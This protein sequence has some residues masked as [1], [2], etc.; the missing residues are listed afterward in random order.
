[1]Q[2]RYCLWLILLLCAWYNTSAQSAIYIPAE[3]RVYAHPQDTIAIYG[4]IINNGRIVNPAGS[5]INFYGIRWANDTQGRITDESSD[6]ISGTGGFVRFIQPNPLTG[7]STRQWVAGGYNTTSQTGASF[8]GIRVESEQG[9]WLEDLNDL[10][11]NRTL[12]L[13]K[14]HLFLNGWNL[15]IGRFSPGEILHYSPE[16]FIVTDSAFGGGRLY[17]HR[18]SATDMHVVFP[19]GTR[20]GSYTPLVVRTAD[21]PAQF[22]ASVWEDVRSQVTSGDSLWDESV[23]RTWEL[24]TD[25]PGARIFMALAHQV[26]DE[27]AVFSA[28]R[29]SAYIARFANGNWET[30][31]DQH[32]P[33]SPNIFTTGT[34]DPQGAINTKTVDQLPTSAYFTKFVAQRTNNP[35]KT[36]LNFFG[37]Y[38][39]ATD[40]VLL[41]WI[42]GREVNCDGFELQRRQPEDT[43]F[44]AI[45]Y[46]PSRA[47]NGNSAIPLT[48]TY[49]DVQSIRGFVFYRLKV[50]MKDGSFFYS[51]IVAV[52]GEDIKGEIVVWPNPVR[53]NTVHIYFGNVRNAKAIELLNMI[54]RTVIWQNFPEPR[55]PF[56][57]FALPVGRLEKGMYILRIFDDKQHTMH[58]Q[59]L[60]FM[61]E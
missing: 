20:P 45:S 5:I 46:T 8:P 22:G 49:K 61:Q 12:D 2:Y 29:S 33:E 7:I 36:I 13:V 10:R 27:G 57:Y 58:V 39:S 17:R 19:L 60:I 41:R 56:S 48:Y 16:R 35:L 6:G 15:T 23:A 55:Q 14:G 37:A 50:I 38:R 32:I 40:T 43:G 21:A 11:I 30:N 1:M 31:G 34:P 54:G 24:A 3:G 44:A 53:G 26:A 28:N 47:R 42:T 25:R 59:K 52:K 4:N 51:N 18:I 9:L